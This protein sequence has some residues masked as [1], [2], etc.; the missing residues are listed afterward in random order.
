M[1]ALIQR[2][3]QGRGVIYPFHSEVLDRAW[4]MCVAR[5][6][7]G[8]S[9]LCLLYHPRPISVQGKH[10]FIVPSACFEPC[11]KRQRTFSL[12]IASIF[13]FTR[14]SHKQHFASL[15]SPIPSFP[16]PKLERHRRSDTSLRT[17]RACSRTVG[18]PSRLRPRRSVIPIP[19]AR[20]SESSQGGSFVT[21]VMSA[22]EAG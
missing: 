16:F 1:K 22:D 7:P 5:S 4:A 9:G 15:L 12:H 19:T 6:G 3:K 21:R 8:A 20:I 2:R 11:Q 10:G 17:K 13:L 18:I 14:N